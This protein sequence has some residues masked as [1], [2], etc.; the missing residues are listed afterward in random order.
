MPTSVMVLG[1]SFANHVEPVAPPTTTTQVPGR[2][3][4]KFQ[5]T[6]TSPGGNVHLQIEPAANPTDSMP[7]NIYA[8]FVQPVSSVPATEQRTP[9]WFFKSGAPNSSVHSATIAADGTV[10]VKVPGV[11]PSLE[12]YFVQTVMEHSA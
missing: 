10:T 4:F 3:S 7:T 2:R 1:P 9:D 12:P 5:P 8:F 11:K 6:P